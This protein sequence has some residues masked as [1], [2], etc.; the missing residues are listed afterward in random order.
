MFAPLYVHTAPPIPH[1]RQVTLHLG[2]PRSF[3]SLWQQAGRAGRSGRSSLSIL[4]CHDSPVDQFFCRNPAVLLGSPPEP[5]TLNPDNIH[6][7]RGH[8]LC[9]A[10]EIPLNSETWDANAGED[11]TNR[12]HSSS[13]SSFFSDIDL[14]GFRYC[15]A[16]LSL[17]ETQD[18]VQWP[19]THASTSAQ[20]V[21]AIPSG[22]TQ[23]LE[24]VSATYVEAGSSSSSADTTSDT[25][26]DARVGIRPLPVWRMHPMHRLSANPSKNVSLRLIDPITINVSVLDG[27]G[28]R[29]HIPFSQDEYHTFPIILA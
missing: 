9:A 1:H 22:L 23:S 11:C 16:S 17:L 3:S 20:R 4:V 25:T 13:S 14:W 29:A 18:L 24:V 8:L 27:D 26:R 7:L 5:A 12:T 10:K 6:V 2:F 28:E 15:E 19:P 21:A